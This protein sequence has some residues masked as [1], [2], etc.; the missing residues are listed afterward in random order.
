VLRAKYGVFGVLSNHDRVYDGPR[1]QRAL[2]PAGIRMLVDT[3][4]AVTASEG[5]SGSP[6]LA[7][8]GLCGTTWASSTVRAGDDPVL[9]I[10]HNPD[11]FPRV[12]SRACSRWRVT[13]MAGNLM[14]P[15]IGALVVPSRYGRRY[16]AGHVVEG[17]R[18]LS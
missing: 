7:T 4:V 17:G 18:H 1:V 14:L 8:S 16:P 12:P 11:V 5:L 2:E 3:A 6:V 15:L 13:R 9:V 10:T